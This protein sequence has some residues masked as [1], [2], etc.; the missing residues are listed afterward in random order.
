METETKLLWWGYKHTSGTYQAK[1][2]FDQRD[3]KDAIESPFVA[4]FTGPFHAESRDEALK[5]VEEQTK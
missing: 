5:I 4:S 2:Y 3:I 1:R